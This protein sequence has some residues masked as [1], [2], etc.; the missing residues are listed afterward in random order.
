M[1]TGKTKFALW[2][3]PETREK[4]QVLY[5]LDNCKSQSEYI[6]KAVNFYSDYLAA[7]RADAFLPGVLAEILEGK[8]S[9][10]G[11]RIGKVIF[12]MAVEE[13]IMTH[14]LAADTDVDLETLERLRARCVRDVMRTHGNVNFSE[15]VQFQKGI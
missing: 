1:V 9:A 4:V 10:L 12:K 11:D 14:L 5:R 13:S 7:E 3:T 15:S 2:L 8:L 6:E